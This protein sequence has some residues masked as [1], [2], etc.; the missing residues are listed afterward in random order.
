[1]QGGGVALVVLDGVCIGMKYI[2]IVQHKARHIVASLHEV[3]IIGINASYHV[4]AQLLANHVD[5][6]NLLALRQACA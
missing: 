4:A 5:Q 6:S 2:W 1:M 3:V